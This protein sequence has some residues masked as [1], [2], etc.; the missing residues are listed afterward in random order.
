MKPLWSE[1]VSLGKP[2]LGNTVNFAEVCLVIKIYAILHS[3]KVINYNKYQN[4]STRKM[5]P[6]TKNTLL[7]IGFLK[8]LLMN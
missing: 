4:I 8:S 6:W 2:N 5:L 7:E 1:M 3:D